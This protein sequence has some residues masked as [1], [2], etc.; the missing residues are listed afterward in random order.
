MEKDLI[1]IR[2]G[3]ETLRRNGE[4]PNLEIDFIMEK[5]KKSLTQLELGLGIPVEAALNSLKEKYITEGIS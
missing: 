4:F 1:D 3:F 2:E 5:T